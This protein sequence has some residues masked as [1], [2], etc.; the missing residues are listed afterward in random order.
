M[1]FKIRCDKTIYITGPKDKDQIDDP[2]M[3]FVYLNMTDKYQSITEKTL[4]TIMYTYENLMDDFDWLVRANDDTFLILENLRSFLA[5]KCRDERVIYGKILKMNY[6]NRQIYTSG[7]NTRG[8][9]QGGSGVLISNEAVKLFAQ[10]MKNDS[11]FCTMIHGNLEDQEISDCLRKLNI[12]P[13]ETRDHLNRERF[14]M[15]P[16]EK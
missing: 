14:F 13:G 11:K 1:F 15:D 4:K 7:D 10:A 3:P 6:A 5:N 2:R 9:L 16:F 8:F 12:Y